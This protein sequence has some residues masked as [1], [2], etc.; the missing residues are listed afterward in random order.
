[1]N[2]SVKEVS[3]KFV[4][5]NNYK[6]IETVPLTTVPKL[7]EV[8]T[9]HNTYYTVVRIALDNPTTGSVRVYCKKPLL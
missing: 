9:L 5:S 3:V 7:K 8:I 6:I 1:M 4:D 2:E